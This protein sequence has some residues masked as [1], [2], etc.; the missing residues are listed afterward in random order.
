MR[1]LVIAS[2]KGHE[3]PSEFFQ[4]MKIP[5]IQG[6][7]PLIFQ[8]AEPSL[9]LGFLCGCIRSAIADHR[10]DPGSQ[11]FHLSVLIG[12]T[13]IKVEN[14]W[15]A[16]FGD[17]WF[18]DGHKIFE[19]VV[20]ESIRSKD[21]PAGIINQC[22]HINTMLLP[23]SGFQTGTGAGIPA[24][25]LIDMWAFITAHILVVRQTFL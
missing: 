13:V 1:A 17:G 10:S 12:S 25:Y 24:P 21:K 5:H 11:K 18:H 14:L 15:F 8:G 6:C 2:D 20:K 16:I 7:H 4:C 3:A 9:N 22:D 23:I 19:C